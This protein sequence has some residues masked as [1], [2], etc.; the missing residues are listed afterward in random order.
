MA[1]HTSEVGD[2]NNIT[3][4]LCGRKYF[5]TGLGT[6]NYMKPVIYTNNNYY[7]GDTAVALTTSYTNNSWNHDI[8]PITSINWTWAEIDALQAGVALEGT[9]YRYNN[10]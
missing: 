3:I 4:Y 7:D 9:E 8:N 2:I 10:I 6:T 1:D 5:D